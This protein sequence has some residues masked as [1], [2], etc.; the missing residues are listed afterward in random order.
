ML[1]N[2]DAVGNS[3]K[4][5]TKGIA[6][7][8]AV[9]AAT[10]LF[11]AFRDAISEA[12]ADGSGPRRGCSRSRSTTG[13]AVLRH[14]GR[15]QP[16]NLVGLIIGAAVVFLFSGLAINAVSRAAGA[17]IF[18]VR[19]QFREHPGIMEGTREAGIRQ[20]RRHRDPRFACVN[21]S[22]RVCWPCSL[23]SPLVSR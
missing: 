15:G 14:P 13:P 10:A 23:R 5:I 11:G 6:I 1:T 22:R 8:T 2:L 7:A 17:V 9:L 18:E 4:A 19:R 3:T 16:A 20:G 21:W 12:S